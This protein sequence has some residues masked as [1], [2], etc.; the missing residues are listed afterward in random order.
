MKTALGKIIL[1]NG[2]SSA[3]KSSIARY[4]QALL[5][6]SSSIMNIDDY[7]RNELTTKATELDIALSSGKWRTWW[8]DLQLILKQL[9]PKEKEAYFNSCLIRF[10]EH[11]KQQVTEGKTVIVDM[12]LEDTDDFLEILGHLP[13]ITVLIYAPL[14]TILK[15][16]TSRNESNRAYEQRALAIA[17]HHFSVLYRPKQSDTDSVVDTIHIEDVKN[18]GELLRQEG[19]WAKEKINTFVN[20]FINQFFNNNKEAVSITPVLNYDMVIN[21]GHH[22]SQA[23]AREIAKQL[24]TQSQ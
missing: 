24:G 1:L 16:V 18:C 3:G 15:H 11:I 21:T 22:S 14:T 5:D 10:Y 19:Y 9:P 4:L 7:M 12:V 20:D 8:E 2:T 17:L 6:T 13:R 23:C